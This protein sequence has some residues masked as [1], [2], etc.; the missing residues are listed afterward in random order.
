MKINKD[1]YK[2]STQLQWESRN[3]DL[4]FFGGWAGDSIAGSYTDTSCVG[5]QVF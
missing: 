3:E 5:K 1:T 4:E 2:L